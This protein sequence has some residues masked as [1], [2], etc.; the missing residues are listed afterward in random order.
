MVAEK[1]TFT[2]W[3]RKNQN[4]QILKIIRRQQNYLNIKF[5][6]KKLKIGFFMAKKRHSKKGL[7]VRKV[8]LF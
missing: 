2:K 5:L 4:Y 1:S 6:E 8:A 7:L 3:S